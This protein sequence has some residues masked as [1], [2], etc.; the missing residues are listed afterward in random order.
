MKLLDSDCCHLKKGGLEGRF[1]EC[2]NIFH[3]IVNISIY[4]DESKMNVWSHS[5]Q[6]VKKLRQFHA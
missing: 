5:V 2:T 3:P 6:N 4:C 1:L